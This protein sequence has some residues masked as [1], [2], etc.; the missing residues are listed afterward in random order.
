M[1]LLTKQ[2]QSELAKYPLYSQDGKGSD[3]VAVAKF[4]LCAGAW[5]WY[6]LEADLQT[7]EMFGI[8]INVQGEGEYGYFSLAELESIRTKWGAQVERDIY[9]APGKLSGITD[10][11]YLQKF[12][13]NVYPE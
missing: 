11:P 4:F 7:N 12:L 10:D 3:A 6:V 8:V 5:T 13:Q 9:F 1:K 2:L